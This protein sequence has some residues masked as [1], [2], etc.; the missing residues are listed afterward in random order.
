MLNRLAPAFLGTERR[1]SLLRPR[2]GAARPEHDRAAPNTT[3]D[4]A[5]AAPDDADAAIAI[6]AALRAADASNAVTHSFFRAS[7]ADTA[8]V[9]V[10]ERGGGAAARALEHK[11]RSRAEEAVSIL[12]RLSVSDG[13]DGQCRS[14]T[15]GPTTPGPAADDPS[16]AVRELLLHNLVE[17][18][19]AF[20]FG[21]E[22]ILPF[23]L[24]CF[25]GAFDAAVA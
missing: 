20:V 10:G 6:A 22:A 4:D 8:A 25:G 17:S 16:R 12:E 14:S 23:F 5:D 18:M 24:E 2:R 13:D 21:P 3:S 19:A 11:L 9:A 7:C 15:A 1:A